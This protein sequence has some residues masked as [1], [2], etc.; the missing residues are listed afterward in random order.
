MFPGNAS[1]VAHISP[2][3][4]TVGNSTHDRFTIATATLGNGVQV[5]GPSFQTQGVPATPMILSMDAGVQPFASLPD[6]DKVAL[7]LCYT[8]G[9]RTALGGSANAALDPAK[10][11]G[12]IVVCIRGNNVLVNKA[13]EVKDRGGAA[14]ILLNLPAGLLPAPLAGASA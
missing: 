7:A 5:T 11:A 9:D 1:T 13:Q 6:A 3:L 4:I 10:V 14:M 2:W 12:K 8:A